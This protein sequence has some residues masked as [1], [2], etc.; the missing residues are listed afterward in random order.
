MIEHC[1]VLSKSVDSNLSSKTFRSR[2]GGNTVAYRRF[3][4]GYL[5]MRGSNSGAMLTLLNEFVPQSILRR[6][7]FDRPQETCC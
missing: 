2:T 6:S 3:P 7:A 5:I 1:R 4:G